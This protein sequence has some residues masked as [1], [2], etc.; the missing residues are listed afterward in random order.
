MPKVNDKIL[1]PQ[2]KKAEVSLIV[3]AA[4]ERYLI[5]YHTCGLRPTPHVVFK[6]DNRDYRT[7]QQ[8]LSPAEPPA[9]TKKKW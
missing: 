2:C 6:C 4:D 7:P 5:A 9:P 8:I 1:C 3:N